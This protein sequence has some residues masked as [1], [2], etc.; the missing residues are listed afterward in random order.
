[1][2]PL[3]F[4]I[5]NEQYD[6]DMVIIWG[7]DSRHGDYPGIHGR[8]HNARAVWEGMGDPTIPRHV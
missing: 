2:L 1:M 5:H 6:C 8:A 4:G 3:A 7:Y